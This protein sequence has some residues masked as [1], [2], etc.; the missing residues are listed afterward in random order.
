MYLYLAT[1]LEP[2]ADYAGPDVD[3]RLELQRFGWREAVA[4]AID[5][6]ISDAK[7]IVGLLRLAA[8]ADAGELPDG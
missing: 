1:G 6:R 2:L 5:G 4:M 3:E 7:S 8:L